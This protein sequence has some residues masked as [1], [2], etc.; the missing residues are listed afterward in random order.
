M[1]PAGS[2]TGRGRLMRADSLKRWLTGMLWLMLLVSIP[3]TSFPPLAEPIGGV[4]V[5]PLMI[6]PLV[7]LVPLW[8]LPDL[9]EGGP[10]SFVVWPLLGFCLAA[11]LAAGVAWFL[12]LAEFKG[13]TVFKREVRALATLAVGV[14]LYLLATRYT[15]DPDRRRL[16]MAGIY[17]GGVIMLVWSTVQADYVLQ[18]LNNVPQE[19]NE[20][21]RLFSIRDLERNRVTGFAFEPSWLGDQLVV[22]YL[23]LWLGAV[24]SQR[25]ILR[26][27][28]GLFSLELA[29]AIWAGWILF[30]TRSRLSIL[31][32]LAV[33]GL[34]MFAGLWRFAGWLAGWLIDRLPWEDRRSVLLAAIRV[35]LIACGGA[36]MLAIGYGLLLKGAQVD[37]RMRR[38][39]SLRTELPGIQEQYPFTKGYEVANRFAVAERIVYWRASLWP[40]ERYPITGVGPGNAGFMFEEGVPAYGHSLRETRAFIDPALPNFPNPKNLWIR[41]LSETGLVGFGFYASWLAAI[42]VLAWRLREGEN[43]GLV[44]IGTAGLLSLAMQCIE[45]FSLD[46][47]ALPQ[48]WI[49]NGL[50]TGTVWAAADRG[51]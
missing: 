30:M 4:T 31:A 13:Q 51:G 12:P 44:W 18:G 47:Y 3:V 28:R 37:W 20:F 45:G 22:L 15:S 38:V 46:S 5:A 19:L 43:P 24:L 8:L 29:L 16:T 42:G 21:H 1:P 27:H 7:L 10:I 9:A 49:M 36:I 2:L 17:L 6:L 11:L 33:A 26:F 34:L 39:L 32:L 35:L 14:G 25:S 41:L 48:L 50:L 23:P 40:F